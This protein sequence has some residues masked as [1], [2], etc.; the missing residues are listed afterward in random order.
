MEAFQLLSRGGARFDKQRF[1]SDVQLF[2]VRI[3]INEPLQPHILLQKAPAKEKGVMISSDAQLPPELDFFKY[4]KA[5]TEKRKAGGKDDL[6][7]STKEGK[8]ERKRR[9]IEDGSKDDKSAEEEV[10][11][12]Q[13]HRV[14]CKG[15]D[16]PKPITSFEDLHERYQVPPR[17]L[18][19]LSEN[20]YKCPTGIQ[21][22]GIP[23][24]LEVSLPIVSSR[25]LQGVD[26]FC[27]VATLPPFRRLV[28]VKLWHI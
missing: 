6:E 2:N 7:A 22:H 18:S 5:P 23:I 10:P 9:K 1:K 14:T 13:K 4:A 3:C 24:L 26:D 27:S 20:N 16:V 17:L 28:Q 8:S 25:G 21:A 19:N 11:V 12:M 15:S